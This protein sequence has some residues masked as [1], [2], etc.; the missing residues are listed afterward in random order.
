VYLFLSFT[1]S[2]ESNVIVTYFIF[3]LALLSTHFCVGVH[4][5]FKR[6]C[7]NDISGCIPQSFL[8]PRHYI[9]G[10]CISYI[11]GGTIVT[12]GRLCRACFLPTL[13]QLYINA[14]LG[15]AR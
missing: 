8:I 11:L 13:A 2:V 1:T 7:G 14:I 9:T 12:A 15:S 5:L 3:F 10:F 6:F 4:E